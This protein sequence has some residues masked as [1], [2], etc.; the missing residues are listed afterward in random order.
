MFPGASATA[1]SIF[2]TPTV[3]GIFILKRVKG[4]RRSPRVFTRQLG[5][6]LFG[7]PG[8]KSNDSVTTDDMDSDIFERLTGDEWPN[9]HEVRGESPTDHSPSSTKSE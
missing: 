9:P 7:L 5:I 1:K 8:R 2:S 6:E 4:M 3:S